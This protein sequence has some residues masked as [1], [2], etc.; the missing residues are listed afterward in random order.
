VELTVALL[1]VVEANA[2][3]LLDQL[4]FGD[5]AVSF[6]GLFLLRVLCSYEIETPKQDTFLGM[7]HMKA[8]RQLLSRDSG[9]SDIS[10][11]EFRAKNSFCLSVT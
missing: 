4:R 5:P 7:R 1:R 2:V 10:Q 11:K 8:P 3:V 9:C 6:R